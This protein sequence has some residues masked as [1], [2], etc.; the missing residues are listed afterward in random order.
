MKQPT[1]IYLLLAL[2]LLG[3]PNAVA[4]RV[5]KCTDKMKYWTT[6]RKGLNTFANIERK[7]R[8]S[9]AVKAGA[10]LIRLAPNKW[11]NSRSKNDIGDFLLGPKDSF[12]GVVEKDLEYL[13]LVLDDAYEVGAKVVL[14]MISL[15]GSRW[16]QHNCENRPCDCSKVKCIQERKLW[17]DFKYHEMSAQFWYE[18]AE[19]LKN[20]PAVVGYNILNEP[21][22]ERAKPI[23]RDWYTGD[24][25][26][27]QAGIAGTPK[28]LN[29]FYKRV[30]EKIREADKCTPIVID[31]GFYA[32]PHGLK[33]FDTEL[34]SR[35]DIIFSIHNYI[36]YR[37][38][39]FSNN[40]RYRYPGTIPTGELDIESD[41]GASP[42]F[43]PLKKWERDTFTEF[44][45]SVLK[46]VKNNKIKPHKIFVGEFGVHRS[47]EGAASYFNDSIDFFNTQGWH[48]AFYSYRGDDGHQRMDY[49]LGESEVISNKYW[50]CSKSY[51][52]VKE[53]VYKPGKI[54]KLL[55]HKLA[56]SN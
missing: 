1:L 11:L 41:L 25:E 24:Y 40:G 51:T 56:Q 7:E 26:R 19:K 29:L 21:S 32:T 2:I 10:Q 34:A 16:K 45:S 46:W 37:F 33:V 13:K 53:N 4:D 39:G 54:W 36:P 30:I 28:D 20:H 12:Q 43:A 55:K 44:Y 15:P 23:F 27:W 22:P 31:S 47:H 5:S 6:Q 50:K 48:W 38:V 49:E 17:E 42:P 52:C 14:S 18:I 8:L 3:I 35:D 9:D